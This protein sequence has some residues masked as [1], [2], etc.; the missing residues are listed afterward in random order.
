MLSSF[1]HM[2]GRQGRAA[3]PNQSTHRRVPNKPSRKDGSYYYFNQGGETLQ[4]RLRQFAIT[5]FTSGQRRPFLCKRDVA[6]LVFKWASLRA[7]G[8]YYTIATKLHLQQGATF[9]DVQ[10]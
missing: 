1:C 4:K 3:N 8:P 10:G 7:L 2:H 5:A 6:S 9:K